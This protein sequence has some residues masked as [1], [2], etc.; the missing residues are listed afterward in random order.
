MT[1]LPSLDQL[2]KAILKLYNDPEA[3][4]FASPVDITYFPDYLDVVTHPMDLSRVV[5]KLR[6]KRY[7]TPNECQADVD[8]I[9]NNCRFYNDNDSEIV[10]TGTFLNIFSFGIKEK[11]LTISFFDTLIADRLQKRFENSLSRQEEEE[12]KYETGSGIGMYRVP[13]GK[14]SDNFVSFTRQ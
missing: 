3:S 1:T 13:F 11:L 5:R 10:Q 7:S 8:L 4:V 12:D 2:E 6:A 14:R 9:W